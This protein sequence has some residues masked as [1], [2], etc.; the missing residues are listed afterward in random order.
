MGLLAPDFTGP[1]TIKLSTD[2]VKREALGRTLG[3]AGAIAGITGAVMYLS[4]SPAVKAALQ[5][6]EAT[7]LTLS[8]AEAKRDATGKSL[9]LI[10]TG[11]GVLGT[12][13]AMSG[14]PK[15]REKMPFLGRI[16]EPMILSAIIGA[17]GIGI[18]VM[19]RNQNKAL[20]QQRYAA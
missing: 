13:I 4:S 19:I 7:S 17:V 20:L 3:V 1:V 14:N 6:K 18:L 2:D 5:R 15:M 10:G 9:A 12:M 11:V 8:A 16:T